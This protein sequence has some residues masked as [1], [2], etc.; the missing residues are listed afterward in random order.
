MLVELTDLAEEIDW[1]TAHLSNLKK[2]KLVS[3]DG[4]QEGP[5]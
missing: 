5:S 4:E 3:L 1:V 2:K